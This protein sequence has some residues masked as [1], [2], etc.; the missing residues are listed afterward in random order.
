M[1]LRRDGERLLGP[2]EFSFLMFAM[3][4]CLPLFFLGPIGYELGLSLQQVL[5]AALLGNL[6]V[7]AA[8][9]LNGLP[10]VRERIGFPEHARRVFGRYHRVPV[11][12]RGLV[13]GLWYGVEAFN[14]ALAMVLIVLVALGYQ[15][16]EAVALSFRLLPLALLVYVATI[17]IV[18]RRGIT[19]VGR[20]AT[21]AGP[22]LLLYFAW[23][24]LREPPAS[25]APTAAPT[26]VPWLSTPFLAYLAVQTNWWATVAVN[27]SDLSR[28]ARDWRTVWIGVLAGMVGGQLLGTYLSYQLALR[29]GTALPH[30]II[31]SQSPGT[32][33]VLLGLAFAF[34]APWTTDLSA[35]LPALASLVREVGRL[36]ERR[37]AV[38]AGLLGLVLAP[39]Y[40]MDRA[41]E[42]VGYVATF[43]ASYG[44]LLGPILGAMLAYQIATPPRTDGARAL[45]AMT[46]GILAAYA[47][48]IMQAKS[49]R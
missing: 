47:T 2:V 34:L 6:V 19:A 3:A 4:S 26:G 44:V 41:Q 1:G 45:L 5:V 40:L 48:S 28:A 11:L 29:A 49:N 33:A 7:A 42:I 23:L 32:L 36:D 46:I 16:G 43:A 21:M 14:G 8:M 25:L 24:A 39:W 35:N 9:A 15:G 18:F 22:I 13:G 37:A 31:L 20:A 30:E 12:L 10:G 17:I 27:M 38:A